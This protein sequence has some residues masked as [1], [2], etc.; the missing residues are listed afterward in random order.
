ML[1][2]SEAGTNLIDTKN[3]LIHRRFAFLGSFHIQD[4]HERF[5]G[6]ALQENGEINHANCRCYEQ[7][8]QWNVLLIDQQNEREGNGA[9]KAAI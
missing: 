2:T 9:S 4:P 1:L 5:Y 6:D 8:L 3:Y 7:W